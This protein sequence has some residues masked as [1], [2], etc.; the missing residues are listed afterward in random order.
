[1]SQPLHLYQNAAEDSLIVSRGTYRTQDTVMSKARQIT[2]FTSPSNRSNDKICLKVLRILPAVCLTITEPQ[3]ERKEEG[4]KREKG[5]R[6]RVKWALIGYL[7]L[8][9]INK[10]QPAERPALQAG[11][12][13]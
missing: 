4:C 7:N 1:M 10:A 9:D 3:G 6:E 5:E 12:V 11:N 8:L 13:H 2:A